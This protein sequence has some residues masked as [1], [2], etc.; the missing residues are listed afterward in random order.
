MKT[1]KHLG[2]TGNNICLRRLAALLTDA[3]FSLLLAFALYSLPLLIGGKFGSDSI[4]AFF[5]DSSFVYLSLFFFKDAFGRSLGKVIFGLYVVDA[6]TD[7]PADP[8]KR[9][10]R[11]FSLML[12]PL[13]AVAVLIS[14]SN[15]RIADKLFEIEVVSKA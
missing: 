14:E 4:G 12:L 10:F 8:A 9:F 7:H 1:Y 3:V 6:G 11:N 15:T 5:K 2:T 13:E